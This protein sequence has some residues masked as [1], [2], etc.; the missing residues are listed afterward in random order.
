MWVKEEILL[1]RIE[2]T[3]CRKRY[4]QKRNNEKNLKQNKLTIFAIIICVVEQPG[5]SLC[6]QD[7]M[8]PLKKPCTG[9]QREFIY[10]ILS[11]KHM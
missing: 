10:S 4:Y 2:S 7:I 11:L 8:N 9:Q 1:R 5:Q 3:T 6:V